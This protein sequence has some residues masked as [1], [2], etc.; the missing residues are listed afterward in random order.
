MGLILLVFEEFPF[1]L[2]RAEERFKD[3]GGGFEFFEEPSAPLCCGVPLF[4]STIDVIGEG[5]FEFLKDVFSGLFAL[6]AS[7]PVVDFVSLCSGGTA[8]EVEFDDQI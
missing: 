8:I 5:S 7:F 2:A 1:P 4:C 3:E 6:E